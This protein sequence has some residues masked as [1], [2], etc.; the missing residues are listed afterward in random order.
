MRLIKSQ[1]ARHA[2]APT[3]AGVF[4]E[5]YDW[6][7]RWAMHFTHN[8]RGM[9]EDLVQD[10]FVRLLVSWPKIKDDITQVE[11]F[12]YSTLK[13]GHL[14][15]LR[16]GR[17]FNFQDLAL[18]EFDDLR[19]SLKEEKGTDPIDVQDDL[20]RIVAYL[21]WRKRSVKSASILLLRF[22]HGYFPE[23]IARIALMKRGSIDELLRVAREEVK[24]YLADPNGVA[25]IHQSKPPELMPRRIAM[26]QERFAEELR[27][28]IYQAQTSTCPSAS[29]WAERYNAVPSRPLSADR[30]AHLVSCEHC[31]KIVNSIF[32]FPSQSSD[33]EV[34]ARRSKDSDSANGK[35]SVE[36]RRRSIAG[37]M[38]RY[39]KLY[40]HHPGALMIAVN[41]EVVAMRDVSSIHSELK[42]QSAVER[43]LGMIDVLSEQGITLLTLFVPVGPPEA[44]PEVRHEIVLSDNRKL[45]L[46]LRFTSESAIIELHYDDPLFQSAPAPAD[47][48]ELAD[49]ATLDSAVHQDQPESGDGPRRP[50]L[51]RISSWFSKLPMPEMSPLL[52]T[53]LVCGVASFVLFVLW[54]HRSGVMKPD[55]VLNRASAAASIQHGQVGVVMQTVHIQT[56]HRKLERTVYRDAEGRRQRKVK[57]LSGEDLALENT[58]ATAGVSWDDPLSASSF[59]YWHAHEHVRQDVVSTNGAG[60]LSLTTTVDDDHVA[61]ETLT[62]RTSDFHT[63]GKTIK[64]RDQGTVE[65]AE[66]SYGIF[67]WSSVN[68]DLFEPDVLASVPSPRNGI[69]PAFIPHIPLPPTEMELNEA[70]LTVRLILNRLQMDS[71]NDLAVNRKTDAVY[72]QGVVASSEEKQ[73]LQIEL[74]TVPHVV[75]MVQT[76]AEMDSHPPS[77]SEI[78]SVKQTSGSATPSPLDHFLADAG[79][80]HA[81]AGA[82]AEVFVN[83]SFSI[84]HE[85]QAIAD[86]LDH[87]SQNAHLS[88]SARTAFSQ[89]VVQHRTALLD[90]LRSEERQLGSL[91]LTSPASPSAPASSGNDVQAMR[92]EA[93]RNFALSMELTMG[94]NDGGRPA[95]EIA[96]QLIAS[97]ADLRTVIQRISVPSPTSKTTA[98]TSAANHE[99]RE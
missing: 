22:F 10:A 59:D 48:E 44:P 13:Y 7:F 8:D 28:T 63:V 91:G 9:A 46:L 75:S 45:E 74:R 83:S 64:L 95:K 96:P 76:V 87:Y 92:A 2:E 57:P 29:Q 73:K 56:L 11:P 78:T 15:E 30:L 99:T 55:D 60:L 84:K 50:W 67:P 85:S 79:F 49:D 97:I 36:Q 65:I 98:D 82:V 35:A 51:K 14:M 27:T 20:R 52:A 17:R 80:D 88:A 34:S 5:K 81:R 71:S 86:L 24:A 90:A 19:L 58:L 18:I 66:V 70:E 12:L 25:F 16:R 4:D 21:C 38:E 41:G 93:E 94:S 68:P 6:L 31:L 43:S 33:I 77:G 23:E 37:G 89:L 3:P 40:E 53:A 42:V 69:H 1:N 32:Q 61:S 54:F 47:L 72:V 26:P 39:R 62:V